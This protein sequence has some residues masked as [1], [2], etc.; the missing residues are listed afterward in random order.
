MFFASKR[1]MN[2]ISRIMNNSFIQ[3]WQT[4]II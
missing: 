3:R 2:F 1:K 4:I